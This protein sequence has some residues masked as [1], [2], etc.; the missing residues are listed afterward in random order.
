MQINNARLTLAIGVVVSKDSDMLDSNYAVREASRS[1][2]R[3]IL[4]VGL[5][6]VIQIFVFLPL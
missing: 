5:H 2:R 3:N 1:F 4:P 6:G